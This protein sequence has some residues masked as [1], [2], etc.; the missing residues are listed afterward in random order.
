MG[1]G[2]D[3]RLAVIALAALAGAAEG[4]LITKTT[5]VE[6][7]MLTIAGLLI[8]YPRA[9][10]DAIGIAL[11]AAVIVLQLRRRKRNEQPAASG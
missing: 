10:L 11:L 9:W 1:R 6:Q 7:V 8:I 5:R 4:W 2:V 3:H